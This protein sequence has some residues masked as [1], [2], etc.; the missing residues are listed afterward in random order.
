MTNT[1]VDRKQISPDAAEASNGGCVEQPVFSPFVGTMI[2]PNRAF[3]SEGREPR[4]S[5][6]TKEGR[7]TLLWNLV[8]TRLDSFKQDLT[9]QESGS[10]SFA[11][12]SSQTGGCSVSNDQDPAVGFSATLVRFCGG[13][14]ASSPM[15]D[16]T[17]QLDR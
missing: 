3:T 17:R 10:S 2:Y 11:G 7:T 9:Y 12:S 6:P 16:A 13:H 4:L 5:A 14:D 8:S 15:D 1:S